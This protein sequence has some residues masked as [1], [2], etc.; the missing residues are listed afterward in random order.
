[1]NAIGAASRL[2]RASTG[3]L[4]P[5][6]IHVI[7]TKAT[8]RLNASPY[9]DAAMPQA[10][11]V[12]AGQLRT[13][14]TPPVDNET[15]SVHSVAKA[16]PRQAASAQHSGELRSVRRLHQGNGL[17]PKADELAHC[18]HALTRRVPARRER[19]AEASLGKPTFE[20]HDHFRG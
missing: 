16:N 2:K 15:R 1:M 11:Q 10:Q 18:P 3:I 12:A 6:I 8:G 19:N 20:R 4:F 13:A 9:A 7:R 5:V 17:H 14:T